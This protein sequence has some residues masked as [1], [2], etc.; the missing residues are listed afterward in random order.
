MH[1]EQSES[2]EM[3]QS[4]TEEQTRTLLSNNSPWKCA[5]GPIP[6][7]V[8]ITAAANS[9][10]K[11]NIP[12]L[13]DFQGQQYKKVD[14]RDRGWKAGEI[15]LWRDGRQLWFSHRSAAKLSH[16]FGSKDY[17]KNLIKKMTLTTQSGRGCISNLLGQCGL[18]THWESRL[19]IATL[20]IL[21]D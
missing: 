3:G 10:K 8:E 17:L 20:N 21:S 16:P 1:T 9:S 5:T 19:L 6:E 7:V 11:K 13:S 14:W 18:L 2:W 4:I 12:A 15:C